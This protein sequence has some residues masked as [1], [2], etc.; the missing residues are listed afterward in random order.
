MNM[1]ST[2]ILLKP[3]LSLVFP[4]YWES[5]IKEATILEMIHNRHSKSQDLPTLK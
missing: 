4:Q 2:F 1:S 3:N 5:Y